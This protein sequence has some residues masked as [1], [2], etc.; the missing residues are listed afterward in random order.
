MKTFNIGVLR[1]RISALRVFEVP[2]FRRHFKS[3]K[4]R[5]RLVN[6]LRANL[7]ADL[8]ESLKKF[9]GVQ[10]ESSK[11]RIFVFEGNEF[12][13]KHTKGRALEGFIA[14]GEKNHVREFIKAHQEYYRK[15]KLREKS[16]YLLRTPKLIAQIGEY[17]VIE[18]I[19]HWIPKSGEDLHLL[20]EAQREVHNVFKDISKKLLTTSLQ[21]CDLIPAGKHNGK[22]VFYSVYD[23]D[24]Y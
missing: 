3:P 6:Y 13:I 7:N 18:R 16:L 12:I 15:N 1:K 21:S 4:V 23:Y 17:L 9:K 24:V 5:E 19:P 2:A 14:H 10:A 20:N 11:V 22:I 8:F